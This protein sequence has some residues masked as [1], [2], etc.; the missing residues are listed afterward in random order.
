MSLLPTRSLRSVTPLGHPRQRARVTPLG[1]PRQ[2]AR[3]TR[4]GHSARSPEAESAS[5]AGRPL[6]PLGH[7]RQG[8]GRQTGI[9]LCSVPVAEWPEVRLDWE[10]EA[11]GDPQLRP[12]PRTPLT[13]RRGERPEVGYNW[14]SDRLELQVF[15]MG[16]TRD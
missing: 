2:R 14:S 9:S 16:S 15:D 11:Q 4:G 3:V 8:S 1:H 6:T 10:P 12:P 7:P 13:L 5:H